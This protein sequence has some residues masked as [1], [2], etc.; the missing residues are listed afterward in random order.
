M[1]HIPTSDHPSDTSATKGKRQTRQNGAAA[2]E[3]AFANLDV[4]RHHLIRR[5]Q[6]RALDYLL[7]HGELFAPDLADTFEV[8]AKVRRV[9][10]GAA[11]NELARRRLTRK[12][13]APRY[14]VHNGRHGCYCEIWALAVD[15]DAVAVWKATHP[16][17]PAPDDLP[18][19]APALA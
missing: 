2:R 12:G 3:D 10:I 16:I 6:H 7:A 4:W 15:A 9:F 14:T 18:L 13:S 11:M 8:P 17:P 5:F 19:F 1:T